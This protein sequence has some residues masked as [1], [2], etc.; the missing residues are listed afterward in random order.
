MDKGRG[1][2]ES[3][4]EQS[5]EVGLGSR[6]NNA[7]I[8]NHRRRKEASLVGFGPPSSHQRVR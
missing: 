1:E 3:I 4:G 8:P 5:K 6:A 7:I 2:G